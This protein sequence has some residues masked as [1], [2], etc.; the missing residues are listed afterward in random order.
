MIRRHGTATEFSC[1]ERRSEV[2][3]GGFGVRF[4]VGQDSNRCF[5]IEA[6]NV[7]HEQTK[8]DGGGFLLY[9]VRKCGVNG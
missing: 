4:E 2:P 7:A 9:V 3:Q 8:F 1:G 6:P 5:I